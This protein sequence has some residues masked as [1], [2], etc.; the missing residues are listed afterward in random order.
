[1]FKPVVFL[2]TC[3]LSVIWA[4]AQNPEQNLFTVSPQTAEPFLYS[5]TSLTAEDTHW[6]FDY[7][8]S[9]GQ[10]VPGSLGYDGVSQQFE[11]GRAHV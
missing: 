9:Y 3:L 4:K 7:S 8:G 1:M 6:S 10:N 11:I 5:V 2:L